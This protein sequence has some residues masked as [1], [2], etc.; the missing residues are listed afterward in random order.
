[1]K[2]AHLFATALTLLFSTSAVSEWQLILSDQGR[3]VELDRATI[4]PSD[5]D[6]KVA[7]G[8][9]VLSPEQARQSGYT[10]VK[11]LNRY[12][13]MNRGFSTI[14]RVYLDE[15]DRV[16]REEAPAEPEP[17]MVT[18]NSVDERMWREVCRPPSASDL[19]KIA[20]DAGRSAANAQTKQTPPKTKTKQAAPASEPAQSKTASNVSKPAQ[21]AKAEQTPTPES[22]PREETP[23]DRTTAAASPMPAQT[24]PPQTPSPPQPPPKTP[25]PRPSPPVTTTAHKTPALT[26]PIAPF[27]WRY[28]GDAGPEHWGQLRPEWR[29]CAEGKRQSPIDLHNG[30]AVDLEPVKFDYRS[31]RFRV[32][33]TGNTLRVDVGDGMGIELRGRRYSLESFTLHRPSETRIN[34][35][36]GDM[37]VQFFH[38]DPEGRMAILEVILELGESPNALIQTVLNNLPLEADA[39]YMPAASLDLSTFLPASPAHYLYTGSLPTPPCTEGV[40]W[41]VMKQTV[42]VS[43]EQLAV[44]GRLYP[45]NVRPPQPLNDRLILESR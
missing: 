21:T 34:G 32:T 6:T 45:H 41:V 35:Q 11:A 28:S 37:S 2:P 19:T 12:D 25:P 5:R 7:W 9:V 44:F 40:T 33:D 1:M 43:A 38:S 14:K 24:P 26:T 10:I 27:G 15:T 42:P 8:R 20:R 13:C 18:R 30:V 39:Y 29:L 16:Q 3:R 23:E 36:M 4:T 17:V 31:S 22:K